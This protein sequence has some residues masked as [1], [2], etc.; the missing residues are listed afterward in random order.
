[1][2]ALE[3]QPHSRQAS[4]M[5]VAFLSLLAA[6]AFVA[7]LNNQLIGAQ[8]LSPFPAPAVPSAQA[9]VADTIPEAT[10][11]PDMQLAEAG[12]AVPRHAARPDPSADD[13]TL[14]DVPAPTA[15]EAPPAVDAAATAPDTEPAPP[16]PAPDNAAPPT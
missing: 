1:M 13:A 12:P 2:S 3:I 4:T 11:A 8:A 15:A 16:P 5:A 9:R 6:G 7:G 10:P 14:V